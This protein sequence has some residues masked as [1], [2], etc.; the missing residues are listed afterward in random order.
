VGKVEKVGNVMHCLTDAELQAIVDDEATAAIVAHATGC[1]RCRARLDDRRQ[2]V[3]RLAMAQAGDLPPGLGARIERAIASGPAVRGATAFRDTPVRSLR[4]LWTAVAAAAAVVLVVFG[5][6]PKFGTPTSLSAAEIIGRSLEQMTGGRGVEVLEYELVLASAFR[7]QNG[8]SEGP[9]RIYQA[10]DRDNPGRYKLAQY[11]QD[12]VLQTAASQ[13]PARRRRSELMR[14]DGRNYVVHVTQ[15]RESLLSIPEIVQ[16]QAESVLKMMQLTSDENLT[17][18][19][20]PQGRQYVIEMPALPVTS[21]AV[22]LD[23]HGARVV[24]DGGD[25]RVREFTASGVLL[26]QP[27]DISFRLLRQVKAASIT[28]A[29]WEIPIGPDDVVIEGESSGDPMNEVISI[30]LR[31]L[32]KTR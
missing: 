11:D 18:V 31:E 1:D 3:A 21:A 14:I 2:Q 29:D 20:G 22:P 32:G 17:V 28:P 19:E 4:P 13:D 10:F 25:F 9:F 26:T 5:V 8:L 24:I 23:L 27:F 16:A 6:M 7:Q 30:V 12:G 15:L